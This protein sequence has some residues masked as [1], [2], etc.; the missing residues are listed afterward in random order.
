MTIATEKRPGYMGETGSLC[1]HCLRSLDAVIYEEDGRVYMDKT[2]PEHGAFKIYL[3]PDAEHYRWC[4][5]FD[6]PVK[7]RSSE[8]EARFG[9]PK[10]CGLC[11][12]HRNWISLAEI[13]VTYRC[14]M[15]CPVCFM[16]AGEPVAEPSFEELCARIRIM[17]DNEYEGAT[18]QITGGEPT[19][20]EDLFDI[21]R[22]AR[23]VGFG[24]VELNTNGIVL[25]RDRAYV[26]ALKEAGCSN[27]YLQFDGVTADVTQALRGA[28]VHE[29]KLQALE[30][31][32]AEGL[33]VVLAPAV[34]RGVNDHQLADIIQFAMENSDVVEGVS[35]QPAFS[36]GR[37]DVD[38]NERIT[39]GDIVSMIEEQTAGRV[40]ARDF[41]PLT[42]VS[43]LCDCST[44]LVGDG[45]FY[46]PIT[47]GISEEEYK[48]FFAD[49]STQG[50]SF[51]DVAMRKY[52]GAVPR[53]LP[54]LI[55]CF[56]DAWNFDT[57]RAARCN[58]G[59][60][61]H[62]GK[63]VPFCSYHLS[64]TCGN[65]LY[66]YPKLGGAAVSSEGE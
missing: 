35:F 34:V 28:G 50:S 64:D 32:R 60:S 37:F 25:A 19:V 41:Y 59:V 26:R 23:S 61:S 39:M 65:R 42:C 55:M 58:L 48:G 24:V 31:C 52:H 33:P 30:N 36:S 47:H 62:D 9:C 43:P 10:D 15:R 49:G 18:I 27:V 46:F 5:S 54:V 14:N 13:E 16:S 66:P 8:T 20:R 40:K 44:Y 6:F 12:S 3:W 4:E 2:C 29:A 51:I 22:F 7:T 57:K 17:K 1:P 21:V 38:M 63:T 56:M 11:P 53:G 45:D